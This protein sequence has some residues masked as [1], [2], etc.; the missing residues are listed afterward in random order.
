MLFFF[1]CFTG[2]DEDFD[3]QGEA[4]TTGDE[5]TEGGG[6]GGQEMKSEFS[7]PPSR[8]ATPTESPAPSSA[9][10][11][12]HSPESPAASVTSLERPS[13][14]DNKYLD[15]ELELAK[16][17]H[18]SSAGNS[19]VVVAAEQQPLVV[20][21][22]LR[23]NIALASDPAANPDAK[24]IKAVMG[25]N[26]DKDEELERRRPESILNVVPTESLVIQPPRIP[27]YTCL[28]CGIKFSSAS[29]LEAHQTYYCS[30][31]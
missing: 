14:V 15:V 22:K 10:S 2:D 16:S 28:P 19:S 6:G 29:T 9:R 5:N 23:L 18:S 25:D 13:S 12:S 24:E 26:I 30:H 21:P 20:I 17:M 3:E 4:A 11:V 31:R 7:E 27:V 8:T 1:L